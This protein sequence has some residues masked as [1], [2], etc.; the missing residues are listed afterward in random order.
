MEQEVNSWCGKQ[1]VTIDI[2]VVNLHIADFTLI[3]A[4]VLIIL[5]VKDVDFF[6]VC[7]L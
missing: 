5:K 4:Q 3:E 1:K 7:E 2:S 6:G